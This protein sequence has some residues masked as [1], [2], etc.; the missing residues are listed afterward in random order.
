MFDSHARL[1]AYCY[2]CVHMSIIGAC[3]EWQ[4]SLNNL[5]FVLKSILAPL[6]CI[7]LDVKIQNFKKMM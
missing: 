7:C 6:E 5:S 3:I 1:I 2:D 4:F